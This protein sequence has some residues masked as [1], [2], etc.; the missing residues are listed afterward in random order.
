LSDSDE[1][2]DEIAQLLEAELKPQQPTLTP[3]VKE[4][5]CDKKESSQSIQ[6]HNLAQH[7]KSTSGESSTMLQNVRVSSQPTNEMTCDHLKSDGDT[8]IKHALLQPCRTIPALELHIASQNDS[9]AL[10]PIEPS[11]EDTCRTDEFRPVAETCPT[12]SSGTHSAELLW[13]AV[14]V[15]F[16]LSDVVSDVN[17]ASETECEQPLIDK[18]SRCEIKTEIVQGL[19]ST[20][21]ADSRTDLQ[22]QRRAR[23][24]VK[25]E[26]SGRTSDL[27]DLS[28]CQVTTA[29]ADT[30]DMGNEQVQPEVSNLFSQSV[31][32]KVSSSSKLDISVEQVVPGHSDI[33]LQSS[34]STECITQLAPA[35]EL[36]EPLHQ[37]MQS[38]PLADR[39]TKPAPAV[40]L[41]EPNQRD[42]TVHTT[43]SADCITKLVPAVEPVEPN[44][45]DITLQ[46][47]PSADCII[48]LAQAFEQM[49][50]VHSS[51][52]VQSKPSAEC[53]TKSPP[54]VQP[55]EPN[56]CD[57]T[58]HTTSSA[59]CI[60]QLGRAVEQMEPVQGSLVVLIKPSAECVTKSPTAVEPVESNHRDITL[61]STPL[62]DRVTKPAPAALLEPNQRDIT[63]HTTPLADCITKLVPAV[64]PVE[65][66]HRDITLQS[67]PL[68]DRVTK[69]APAALLEPNQRDITVQST[70]LADR[71]AK[72]ASAVEL[73]EPNQRDITVH[74]TPSAGCVNEHHVAVEQSGPSLSDTAAQ[75]TPSVECVPQT[76]LFQCTTTAALI[77]PAPSE[78]AG[79]VTESTSC[80]SMV[81]ATESVQIEIIEPIQSRESVQPSAS[82]SQANVTVSDQ[83][84]SI[85]QQILSVQRLAA[86]EEKESAQCCTMS[87][88]DDLKVGDVIAAP[89]EKVDSH[90]NE[91]VSVESIEL[92]WVSEMHEKREF[93]RSLI[94]D[95]VKNEFAPFADAKTNTLIT[96]EVTENHSRVSTKSVLTCCQV[97]EGYSC[98]TVKL[99]LHFCLFVCYV[100]SV[101]ARQ[102]Q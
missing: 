72:P 51:I 16:G 35:V 37:D 69:P 22:Q 53:V 5:Q 94:T 28:L 74:T 60:T 58:I 49:E 64:E 15:E 63:V 66:N 25:T 77:R 4:L 10:Q 21:V 29:V 86:A 18:S 95:V 52:V 55:V 20:Q 11:P 61:Q 41:L 45:R 50:P 48:Q 91:C 3:H 8:E 27:H 33:I 93:E 62:A 30:A 85:T 38:T 71:V 44:H 40:A 26:Q 65:P 1:S 83:H 73:V 82:N 96:H 9:S 68:A 99:Q 6:Q 42:N 88:L 43:P 54:A 59:H 80:K 81:R 75:P 67:T 23:T 97:S 14:K 31:H 90:A 12:L 13:T 92:E 17:I 98:F 84:L 78:V 19:D 7:Q 89:V 46:S 47:T 36:I 102:L 101:L 87:T 24:V 79:H 100:D 70:P 34:P 39:I 76:E 2:V 57:V 56:H 32:T